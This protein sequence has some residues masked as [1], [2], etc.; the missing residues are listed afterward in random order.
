MKSRTSKRS[1]STEVAEVKRE[2]SAAIAQCTHLGKWRRAKNQEAWNLACDIDKLVRKLPR[3]EK[4]DFADRFSIVEKMAV[5]A[6]I[7][8]AD[9]DMSVLGKAILGMTERELRKFLASI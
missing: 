3:Y 5:I 1:T 2:I 8:W 6:L 7:K 4:V 9:P